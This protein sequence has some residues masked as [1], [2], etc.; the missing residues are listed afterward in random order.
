[1]KRKNRYAAGSIL[2]ALMLTGATAQV[3]ES[4]STTTTTTGTVSEFSP[5]AIVVRTESTPEPV[6]YSFSKSVTYV[7]ETGAPVSREIIK[8]GIPVTVHYVKEGDRM[9]ASRVVVKKTT[10]T[11]PIAESTTTTTTTTGTISEF[12]PQAV[13]LRTE[14]A[15]EPIRYGFSKSVTY[16]DDTGA[17][18]TRERIRPG[19]PVTVHYIREG[20]RMLASKII[21]KRSALAPAAIEEKTTTT[22][23]TTTKPKK[24]D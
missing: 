12:G 22:T 14:S 1:M 8:S 17:T 15:A 6:R 11:R 4:T 23:T 18:I 20:D 19:L 2:F 10:T 5:Q 13:V 16:V 21:V 24:D 7:D 9:L 3:V